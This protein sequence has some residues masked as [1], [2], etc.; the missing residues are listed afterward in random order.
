M[1]IQS[2]LV[3][4]VERTPFQLINQLLC[5]ALFNYLYTMLPLYLNPTDMNLLLLQGNYVLLHS[6]GTPPNCVVE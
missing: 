6:G 3:L 2:L 1:P 4:E 5:A